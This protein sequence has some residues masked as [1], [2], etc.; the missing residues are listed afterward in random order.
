MFRF[1]LV[2]A[3]E[4]IMPWN[5]V[6]ALVNEPSPNRI[7]LDR[8]SSLID[9]TQRS[10]KA[11]RF[12]L[13]A[14]SRRHFTPLLPASPELLANFVSGRAADTVVGAEIRRLVDRV[15]AHL[16]HPLFGGMR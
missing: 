14:G 3:F 2:I 13:R 6:S 12:G 5:W 7:S 15:P 4:E 11:F 10:A 8:H 16:R 1:S 9:R